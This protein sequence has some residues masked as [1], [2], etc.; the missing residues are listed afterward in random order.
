MCM[1]SFVDHVIRGHV[2]LRPRYIIFSQVIPTCCP[3][4]GNKH[5]DDL[6]IWVIKLKNNFKYLA[7][8]FICEHM[9]FGTYLLLGC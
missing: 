8:T 3:R 9:G 4:K 1:V 6:K 2:H 5:T 7:L